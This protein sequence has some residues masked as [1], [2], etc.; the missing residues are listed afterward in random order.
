MVMYTVSY[1]LE[2][3]MNPAF[4]TMSLKSQVNISAIPIVHVVLIE[5]IIETFIQVFKVEQNNSSSSFHA[6][7]YL[8]D[9][10][11]YLS[12]KE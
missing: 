2:V 8:I 6:N 7:L 9:V 10:S 11:A 3:V 4:N 1:L 5:Y 12:D